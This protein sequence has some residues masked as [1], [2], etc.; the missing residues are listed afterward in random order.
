MLQPNIISVNPL[1]DYM[2]ELQYDNG[3][4]RIFDVKPYIKGEW[5]G[6][7]KDISIFNTVRVVDN[8]TIRME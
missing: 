7:L 5:Y 2:L 1:E 3:E 8:W 6:K 4:K